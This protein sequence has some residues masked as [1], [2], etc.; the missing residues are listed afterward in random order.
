[1]FEGVAAYRAWVAASHD[2]GIMS[3]VAFLIQD[4]GNPVPAI[5]NPIV[6]DCPGSDEHA[7]LLRGLVDIL[8]RASPSSMV[9][10]FLRP[11]FIADGLNGG[12]KKWKANGWRKADGKPPAYLTA[13]QRIDQLITDHSLK[14]TGALCQTGDDEHAAALDKL[15]R[16]AK[17]H[18]RPP[19]EDAY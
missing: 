8:E 10:I 4:A 6:Y 2:G 19:A 17:G 18:M 16:I 15:H 14:V 9:Y 12:L 11:K 3:A 1:M 7:A 5:L 13:W